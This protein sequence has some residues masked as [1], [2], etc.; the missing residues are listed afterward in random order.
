MLTRR[1]PPGLSSRRTSRSQK[2]PSRAPRCSM[3]CSAYAH[4]KQPDSNGSGSRASSWTKWATPST[5]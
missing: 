4:S 3:K 1:T 5:R 2:M